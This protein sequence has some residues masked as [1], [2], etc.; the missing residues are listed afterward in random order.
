MSRRGVVCLAGEP[1]ADI[2]Q[3]SPKSGVRAR[4]GS[5]MRLTYRPDWLAREDA[6]PISPTL[7]LRA[8]PYESA[9]LDAWFENLLPE[10]CVLDTAVQAHRLAPVDVFGLLLAIGANCVGA[11]E[12]R[13]EADVPADAR[14]DCTRAKETSGCSEG[15]RSAG[16]ASRRM[17]PP[18]Q[19]Q[20]FVDVRLADIRPLVLSTLVHTVLPGMQRKVAVAIESARHGALAVPGPGRYILKPQ[21]SLPNLP[22]N[23]FAALRVASAAGVEVV[24]SALATLADGTLGHVVERFDRP[25]AGG[26]LRL[27]DFCQLAGRRPCEKYDGS[28]E[29]CADLI[30]RYASEPLVDQARLFRRLLVAWWTGNSHLHLKNLALLTGA[31]G[32]A[33]LSPA[34]DLQCTALAGG[35]GALALP[36]NGKRQDLRREDWMKFADYCGLR[37]A[38]T[39]RVLREVVGAVPTA[40]RAIEDSPLPDAARRSYAELVRRRTGTLQ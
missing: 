25:D 33:R 38:A 39:E 15:G 11:V 17:V 21:S 40:L 23:E 4:G 22:E 8:E 2:D 37:R 27:E 3:A 31:D 10:G 12:V 20:C 5:R 30:R 7:P 29:V 16:R 36:V 1:V 28:G 24:I 34:Y 35:D 14:L 19:A 13:R 18:L 26:K 6:E 32:V 9:S